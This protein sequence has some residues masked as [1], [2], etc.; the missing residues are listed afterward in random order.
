MTVA[1]E[2]VTTIDTLDIFEIVEGVITI[3]EQALNM[4]ATTNTTSSVEYDVKVVA[5]TDTP[6]PTEQNSPETIH[7]D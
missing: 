2:G 1:T 4:L 6:P 5:T 3:T 7:V